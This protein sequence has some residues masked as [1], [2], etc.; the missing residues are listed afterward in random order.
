[1]FG[2]TQQ[3][4]RSVSSDQ[5]GHM[6]QE[7]HRAAREEQG[8]PSLEEHDL[9]RMTWVAMKLDDQGADTTRMVTVTMSIDGAGTINAPWDQVVLGAMGTM[10]RQFSIPPDDIGRRFAEDD[11]D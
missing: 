9:G 10:L 2:K 1:M 11:D 6:V 4:G 5:I 7:I 3:R 8:L